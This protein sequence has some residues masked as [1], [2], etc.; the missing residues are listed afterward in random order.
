MPAPIFDAAVIGAAGL[1]TNIYLYGKDIDFSVEAN[2]SHN[3]DCLGGAGGYSGIGFA[4]LGKKTAYI[5]Y[6]GD[7]FEGQFVRDELSRASINLEGLFTDPEGTARSVNVVY[8]DGRR[9]NFYDGRGS[10]SVTPDLSICRKILSQSRLA[11]FSIVNWSRK[12][13]PVARDMGLTISVDI[14]D[15]VEVN[16]EYRKD[17]I[18]EADV[19]FFSSVNF[20][21][22]EP[23]IK[24]FLSVKKDRLIIAGIGKNG[25]AV[26][27]S[28]GIRF[29]PP[30]ELPLPVVDTNGA[31][32][33][34]ATGFL[35]SYFLDGY[36]LEE[37]ILRGQICARYCC[38]LRG[39]TPGL[40]TKDQLNL[41]Y[42]AIGG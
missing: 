15:V 18:E 37:A 1:D 32:D 14:Q 27:S 42:R 25:C 23:V 21:D 28:A 35:S 6:I 13:L 24:K 8:A 33:S 10:M 19:L 41:Y 12:L 34:L 9:K 26:G 22:P 30:V 16:D 40:I 2:F 5:G 38:S 20:P 29:F 3:L 17:Y 7:D 36:S 31:G 4:Q 39:N 11:H